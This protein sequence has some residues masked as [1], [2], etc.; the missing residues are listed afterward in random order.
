M[1][2]VLVSSIHCFMSLYVS[3]SLSSFSHTQILF[4]SVFS[5]VETNNGDKNLAVLPEDVA[6]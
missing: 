2:A 1:E 5:S 3:L 4:C 6:A